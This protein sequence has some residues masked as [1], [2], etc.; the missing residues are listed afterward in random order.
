MPAAVHPAKSI[1]SDHGDTRYPLKE[2]PSGELDR[3]FRQA[4]VGDGSESGKHAAKGG[5]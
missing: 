2:T 5:L 4:Y 3:G 1:G